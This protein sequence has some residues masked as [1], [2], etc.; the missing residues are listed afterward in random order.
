MYLILHLVLAYGLFKSL[1]IPEANPV[2]LPNVSVI[3][4]G[5]NEESNIVNC[6]NSLSEINYPEELLQIILVNDNSTDNTLELMT[7]A[8]KNKYNFRVINSRDS[9]KGNLKG[10]ANAIDTAIEICTGEIIVCTDADCTVNPNWVLSVVR[11]YQKNTGM[12]CGF[13]GIKSGDSFFASLQNI[14]WMYLLALA[15]SSS[16]LNLILSCIGNNL[17]FSKNAYKSLGGYGAIDFS[18]TEDLAL[19]RKIDS[20]DNYKILFPVDKNCLVYTL[21]C[22]DI[23]ELFSQK[24]R[25]FRG[26][27]G[28]NFFGYFTGF[29]LYSMSFIFAFGIFLMSFKLFLTAIILKFISE[30]LL[31]FFVLKRFEMLKE[32]KYYPA[33]CVYFAFYG[34][35]LPWSFLFGK[36]INWKG[37]KF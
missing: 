32:M 17:S 27:T 30:L 22:P 4:A 11:Y 24:R 26:G 8:A 25:W 36:K 33:F 12:V 35:I 19:M 34:L 23:K 2:I 1:N 7:E 37:Q 9:S 13:T 29:E 6:I 20:S 15:S 28:V 10:K 5:R 18:V 14:D 21:P 3:V 31:L 16:G